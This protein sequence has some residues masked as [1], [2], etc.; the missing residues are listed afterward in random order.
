M[1]DFLTAP[2]HPV[3]IGTCT[4]GP[5][6]VKILSS[7]MAKNCAEIRQKTTATQ[8]F[9]VDILEWRADY[10][11][12]LTETSLFSAAMD[13]RKTADKPVLF[14]LRTKSEGGEAAVSDEEYVKLVE[15]MAA[16]KLADAVDIEINRKGFET[17]IAAAKNATTPCVLSFHDFK[18]TPAADR[19][20]ALFKTMDEAGG[21]VLK[22]AVMPKTPED[23]LS[24]MS[25]A[26]RARRAFGKP[27]IAM[28]MGETGAVTRVAG[29]LFG[30]AATFASTLAASAP[31]QLTVDDVLAISAHLGSPR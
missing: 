17:A 5:L 25:A 24:L 31:G 14:T 30:S 6:P 28:A 12:S 20:D 1:S 27:V 11:D 29:A 21:D 13:M 19:L 23:V 8:K 2:E 15:F 22:V 9:A 10:L 3:Q 26:L 7:V 16:S 4:L 18:K